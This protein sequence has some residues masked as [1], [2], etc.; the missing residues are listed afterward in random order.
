MDR[1]ESIR[2]HA[3]G[4]AAECDVMI[5]EIIIRYG[6]MMGDTIKAGIEPVD[7]TPRLLTERMAAERHGEING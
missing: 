1:L 7:W 6:G 4:V 3:M 5:D 2:D